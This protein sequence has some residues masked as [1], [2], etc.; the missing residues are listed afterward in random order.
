LLAALDVFVLCSDHEAAPRALLEAL[1]AGCAAVVTEVGGMPHVVGA[2]TSE[3]PAL[4]VPPRSPES[5]ADALHELED[6]R[7]RAAYAARA[8]T[9]AE[10]FSSGTVWEAYAALWR[11]SSAGPE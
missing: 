9:R 7:L 3:P 6:P 4:L 8:R 1:A 2:G 11:D 10:A 5:L